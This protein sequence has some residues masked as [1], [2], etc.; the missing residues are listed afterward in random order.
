[1]DE[2]SYKCE[3][4]ARSE[5]IPRLRVSF[6]HKVSRDIQPGFFAVSYQ[7]CCRSFTSIIAQDGCCKTDDVM[8]VR[9]SIYHQPDLIF[10]YKLL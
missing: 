10:F 6:I 1:M 7:G 8:D 3:A 4:F 5:E 9:S 2:V